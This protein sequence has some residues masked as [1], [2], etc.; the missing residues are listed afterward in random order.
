MLSNDF[1]KEP[2]KA[3]V[4]NNCAGAAKVGEVLDRNLEEQQLLF[5]VGMLGFPVS[6]HYRLE[7]YRPEDGSESPFLTLKCLDQDLSFALIHPCSLGL[8]YRV[9]VNDEMLNLLSAA[10]AEQLSALLIVTLRERIEDITVNLQGPLI[11]NPASS[12]G[13][14]L[15]IEH[16]PVRY[17]LIHSGAQII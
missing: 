17:P 12:L 7:R 5:P 11:I 9:S 8:D 1:A 13:L 10:S 2:R 14:Q 4:N 15:V 16:Y 6:R 3:S